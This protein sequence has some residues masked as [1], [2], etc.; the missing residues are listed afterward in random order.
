MM[1]Q[2]VQSAITTIVAPVVM[3]TACA[4]LVG[5]MLTQ[6]N[7]MSERLRGF[8]KERLELLRTDEGGIARVT[9][10]TGAYAMERLLELDAQLPRLLQRYRRI[11]NAVLTMY[12]AV[13]VFMATMLTISVAYAL[14]SPGWATSALV[15]FLVGVVT[16]LAALAQRA[17]FVV[18]GNVVVRYETQR[19]LDLG[20]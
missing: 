18:G 9:D 5:G 7:Q 13:L 19:I 12:C 2:Q 14:Q 16:A 8:A 17:V 6:Y 3:V 15:L 11:R 10:L 1:L 4:I 20:R